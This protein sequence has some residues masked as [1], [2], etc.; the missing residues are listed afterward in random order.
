MRPAK[1]GTCYEYI[2]TYVDDLAIATQN[3]KSLV[4]ELKCKYKFKLK[5]DGPISYHLG[6]DY[7]RDP[8]GTLVAHPKSYIE[9]MMDTYVRIFGA[10]PK[11]CASPLEPND[12]PEIDDTPLCGQKEID[13][14]LTF[15]GQLQWLISLGRF[16]IFTATMTMS[17]FR[18]APRSG[19]IERIKRIYGYLY[20]FK[21]GAIRYRVNN[22]DMSNYPIKDYDWTRS[23]YGN[24]SEVLPKDAPKP[25]GKPI[26]IRTYVDANL[27]H[28]LVTG[29]AVTGVLH[30]INQ[31]PVE[32]YSKRQAT[33]ET[34]TFGAEFVASRIAV[35]QIIDLRSTLRYLG[36]PVTAPTYM[37]GDNQSV[38]KNGTLPHSTLNKRHNILSYHRVRES[39]AAKI[40]NFH[41]LDGKLNYADIL[42]KHWA[43]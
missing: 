22:P 10:N 2:A 19:H 34:A 14:Y 21:E 28:D 31:T 7:Y 25:L 12:H 5:G 18:A 32:W 6:C 9:K 24:V 13:N 42:S 15:I 29:R 11:A 38:V 8:D 43:Y 3:P 16:D 40:V 1:D 41:W 39:I 20:K 33:V 4:D 30:M 26:I 23:V 35:D 27:M 17:R 37:F 36:V